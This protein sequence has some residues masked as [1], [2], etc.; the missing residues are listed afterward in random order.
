VRREGGY[1]GAEAMRFTNLP[2][3]WNESLEERI[4]AK[5]RELLAQTQ[6]H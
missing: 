6:L 2:G 1:E 5:V 3:P 4:A